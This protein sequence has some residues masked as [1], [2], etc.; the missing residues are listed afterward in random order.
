MSYSKEHLAYLK[1]IR[2][3]DRAVRLVQALVLFL[4]LGLWE[5][6]ARLGW[7]DVFILSC[8]SRVLAAI[9]RCID[10]YVW[11]LDRFHDLARNDMQLDVSW[12]V[13]AEKYM[14]MFRSLLN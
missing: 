9:G 1:A 12:T 8:P 2:R 6:G 11:T 14:D 10:L 13:P 7:F 3:H 5:L 4:F